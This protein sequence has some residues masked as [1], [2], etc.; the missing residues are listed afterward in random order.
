M[1]G[2][3]TS[4]LIGLTAYSYV[5]YPAAVAAM[6]RLRPAS[7]TVP[8]TPVEPTLSLVVCAFN[9]RAALP[10]KLANIAALD[11]PGDKL[12]VVVVTDGSDDGSEEVV[13][14]AGVTALHDSRRAGKAAAMRRGV[15]AATGDVVVFSD[16][17]NSYPSDAL[18]HV[19]APF[20]NPVVG[21]VT[22]AKSV[23][24]GE[25]AAGAG[26]KAY[27]AYESFIKKQESRLGC[28][29]GVV[30]EFFAVR[31]ALV[32]ELPPG[33]VNDDFYIAMQVVRGG[34]DVA[35][36][37]DARSE[38]LSSTSL[39]ADSVRRR[40]MTAGRWQA[41]GWWRRTLPLNRPRVVW[42]VVSHKY[43]RLL[44][45]FTMGGA[46]LANALDVLRPRSRATRASRFTLAGQV[47]FY[48][49]AASGSRTPGPR[50]VRLVAGA[51]RYLVRANA[52]S[53]E[54]LWAYLRSRDSLHLWAP[55]E[56]SSSATPAPP[57]ACDPPHRLVDPEK[58]F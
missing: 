45:P 4:S 28:C 29:T 24:G 47:A 35:Y 22:G 8:S 51:A 56:R 58:V 27:W 41:L 31:R 10:G 40:R 7:R 11:Y 36:A 6:A 17:N 32:P 34:Y 14:A 37:P 12:Q 16:A 15:A 13:R 2:V 18:R 33:L 57:V 46:L 54:G 9:E 49:L 55:A 20:A 5:G 44:L 42:Q 19:V 43:L 52:A 39:R 26:E 1:L 53:A 48:A 23:A 21:A 50:P 30:G 38:E 25:H 3:V